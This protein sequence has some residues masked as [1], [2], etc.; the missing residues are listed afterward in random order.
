MRAESSI[1]SRTAASGVACVAGVVLS[2]TSVVADVGT[3]DA[4]RTPARRKT[5]P[6]LGKVRWLRDMDAATARAAKENKAVLV[7]FTEVPG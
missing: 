2:L 5:P 4:V 3:E 6:E 1:R 7:L